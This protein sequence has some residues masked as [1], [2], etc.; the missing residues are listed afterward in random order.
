MMS[1]QKKFYFFTTSFL[2][3]GFGWVAWNLFYFQQS[4]PG[5]E[6]CVLK[7]A[8]GLPCPS[9]G[10]TRSVLHLLHGD[11]SSAILMN[12]IGIFVIIGMFISP[13]WILYDYW[14]AK[15]TLL[16]FYL[17]FIKFF[18]NKKFSLFVIVLVL[19]NWIWNIQKG[20]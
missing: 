6:I 10:T 3:I 16:T 18:S 20:L 9:C 15:T 19:L 1:D 8:V 11:L 4:S 14:Y 13:F 5:L 7:N 12:P 2:I 17:Q